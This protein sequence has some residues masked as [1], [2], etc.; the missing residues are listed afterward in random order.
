MSGRGRKGSYIPFVGACI[1][2]QYPTI[3]A[4]CLEVAS[5]RKR[6]GYLVCKT[7]TCPFGIFTFAK[8]AYFKSIKLIKGQTRE[9]FTRCIDCFRSSSVQTY[10]I[11]R[12]IAVPVQ[13]ETCLGYICHGQIR[14]LCTS[15]IHSD[16]AD[17]VYNRSGLITPTA[18]VFPYEY[19]FFQCVRLVGDIDFLPAFRIVDITRGLRRCITHYNVC[20]V[21][22][23][24]K[25]WTAVCGFKI[26][27]GRNPKD[28]Q[29][30]IIMLAIYCNVETDCER[31]RLSCLEEFFCNY[32]GIVPN[33]IAGCCPVVFRN[34]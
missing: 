13:G 18:I 20:D 21:I 2:F 30:I 29:V 5:V 11:A 19:Q 12:C 28:F 14:R 24:R 6:Y 15:G 26:R 9:C 3:V 10:F 7:K 34:E 17:I 32:N 23:H 8:T 4:G 27:I 31:V 22:S 25:V 33:I 1:V 16:D